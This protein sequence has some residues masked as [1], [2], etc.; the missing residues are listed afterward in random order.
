MRRQAEK[1]SGKRGEE[2]TSLQT[3]TGRNTREDGVSRA[4]RE[5]QD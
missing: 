4:D 5:R 3:S 2:E 1:A